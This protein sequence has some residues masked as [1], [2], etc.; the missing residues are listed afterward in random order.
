[1]QF[2]D[3]ID[4]RVIVLLQAGTGLQ[5]VP[6]QACLTERDPCDVTLGERVLGALR[7]HAVQQQPGQQPEQGQHHRHHAQGRFHVYIVTI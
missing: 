7:A 4:E 3:V 5:H 2:A 1:M 6:P